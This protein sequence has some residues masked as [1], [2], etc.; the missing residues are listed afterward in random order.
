MSGLLHVGQKA[1]ALFAVFFD[2]ALA[3]FPVDIELNLT[4]KDSFL[5]P[6]W[7]GCHVDEALQSEHKRTT[8]RDHLKTILY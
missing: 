2:T 5:G 6:T 8:E 3:S 1:S 7:E 4:T